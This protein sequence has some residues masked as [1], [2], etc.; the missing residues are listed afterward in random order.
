MEL[1]LGKMTTRELAEWFGVSYNTIRKSVESKRRYLSILEDF[2]DYDEVYGGVFIKEIFISIY[3][4]DLDKKMD[5]LYLEE[6]KQCECGLSTIAGMSRKYSIDLE[7]SECQLK[8]RFTKS[9]NRLFGKYEK[10]ERSAL[11]E[12][13]SREYT[14]AVKVD[15]FNTYRHLTDDESRRFDELIEEVYGKVKPEEW[16]EAALLED[17]FKNSDMT[18]EEYFEMKEKR[19][20]NF[21]S[22]VIARLKD[23][24]GIV[25]TKVSQHQ[26]S[27]FTMEQMP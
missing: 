21:F 16:R 9:G 4:K 11:G 15:D 22:H 3:D 24:M 2:A 26:L 14:W 23:E 19:R 17:Y 18:K 12:I 10:G 5:S 8:S 20:F 13:G 1:K 6:I 27:A 7:M 25:V